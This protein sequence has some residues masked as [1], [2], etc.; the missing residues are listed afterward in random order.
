M[1]HLTLDLAK[2][3]LLD[4]T[5]TALDITKDVGLGTQQAQVAALFDVSGSMESYYDDGSV[6]EIAD[7]VLAL[8]MKFDSNKA[9]D[10]FA[11]DTSAKYIGEVDESN[12]FKYV[13]KKVAP[14]VG[15]GT[16]YAPALEAVLAHY[17]LG[18]RKPQKKGLFGLGG[19]FGSK[20]EAAPTL[21]DPV[22]VTFFT[23]GDN[24]DK[25]Q[26]EAIIKEASNYGVFFKFIGIG[27]N[28]FDFLKKLDDMPARTVDN[29]DFKAITDPA[30]VSESQLYRDLLDE[31]PQW[32][33]QARAK[34][35]IK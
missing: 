35:F 19:L 6:Q 34:G 26:A 14:L 4:L 16:N 3:H 22:F 30:K 20:K 2:D 18:G 24:F 10:V 12:F 1:S 29:V 27:R 9:I 21:A 23:D 32:V 17:G 5:K 28:S 15:G 13:E 31:F 33:T 25:P 11:F 8:G 7:R